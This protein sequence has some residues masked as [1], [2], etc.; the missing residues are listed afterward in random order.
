MD[1]LWA[2]GLPPKSS[3]V[4]TCH[5]SYLE[6]R[7]IER[8]Y[9]LEEIIACVVAKN[10]DYWKIDTEHP[11]YPR[12]S[13]VAEQQQPSS[14]VDSGPGT[15]LKKLLAR[16]G[17]T[18]TP[19]CSCNR[20][21]RE[22]DAWGADECEKQERVDYILAAMRENAEKRGLPFIDAAGRFLI[23]RAIKNARKNKIDQ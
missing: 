1:A 23:R 11:A 7:C 22:M 13:R 15:E 6:T 4:I 14:A 2:G 12:A 17:I 19:D 21:A 16:I 20:V 9:S 5:R 3:S 10:G 8:G 18:S